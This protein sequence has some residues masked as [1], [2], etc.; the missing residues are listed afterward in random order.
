MGGADARHADPASA[1][2]LD[3][4]LEKKRHAF[5][6]FY[7]LSN[8]DLLE[9]LGHSKDPTQVQKHIH[10]CFM[11][12][13]ELVISGPT[14]RREDAEIEGLRSAEGEELK[15]SYAVP[16]T[17]AVEEWLSEVERAMRDTLKKL[18]QIS[19]Q[20]V[21]KSRCVWAPRLPV[22]ACG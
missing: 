21:V 14:A 2:Q 13:K 1:P 7:L 15:L 5:P 16:V 20:S 3:Q 18:L 4:Y 9:I 10:K 11:N 17:G 19:L 6:R 22:L 12:V 8:D